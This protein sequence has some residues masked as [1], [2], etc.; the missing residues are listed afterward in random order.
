MHVLYIHLYFSTPQGSTGTR[1]YQFA[2]KLIEQGHQVTIVC[3][4]NNLSA[5][6]LK[7]EFKNRKRE[8]F[9]D[10]IKIIEFNLA[11]SNNISLIKRSLIFLQFSLKTILLALTYQYDLIFATSTPLTVA[12][13]GIAAKWL[14]RKPFVF[15]VRDLWPELPKA[16][17]VIRNKLLLNALSILEW[18]AYHSANY[19]IGLS[20]GMVAG[21]EAR[22]IKSEKIK[23]IPN[24]CDLEI[25]YPLEK[26]ISHKDFT[27]IFAGAHGLANGLDIVLDAAKILQQQNRRDIRILLVGEGKLKAH[28]VQRSKTENIDNCIFMAPVPKLAINQLFATADVGL[29]ILANIPAF[30]YGTS[31]NKFFDYIAAGLPVI[32][33]HPGWLADLLLQHQCG[34]AVPPEDAMAL[35][36]ALITLADQR[37]QLIE[38]GK[39][40]RFLAETSFNRERLALE[41]VKVLEQTYHAKLPKH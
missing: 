23:M 13:P 3:G 19:C 9:V 20:P 24:G 14:R 34:K 15:E 28:L 30:Y 25:F 6:G 37:D 26:K 4:S 32:V 36:N 16:M 21:I 27:A 40:A 41:F 2:K 1:S 17:G 5:T 18:S 39:N 33:N 7:T 12:V 11:Y 8:G 31:P 29:M 22:G 38:M 35:A 10:G